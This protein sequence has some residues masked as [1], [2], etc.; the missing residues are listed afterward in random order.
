MELTTAAEYE[1]SD[2]AIAGE[3]ATAPQTSHRIDLVD[4]YRIDP[5]TSR[6]AGHGKAKMFY[7]GVLIGESRQPAFDAA[8]YLLEKRLALP[9]DK[10]TTYR[11]DKPCLY[12]T[13]GRAAKLAVSETG[14]SG[15]RIVAYREDTAGKLATLRSL[16]GRGGSRQSH[17]AAATVTA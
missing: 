3:L 9:T 14:K 6:S 17:E 13:V 15:P 1:L 2:A 8:R 12:T 11:G 16:N 7:E 10:L 4:A 5:D